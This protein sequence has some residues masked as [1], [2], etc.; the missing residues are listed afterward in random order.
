MKMIIFSRKKV[1]F[2]ENGHLSKE[3]GPVLGLESPHDVPT[4]VKV[5]L[6]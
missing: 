1:P 5:R 4:L 6:E 3:K 2:E